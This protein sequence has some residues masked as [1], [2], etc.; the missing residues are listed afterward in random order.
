[1]ILEKPL[2]ATTASH[3]SPP[4]QVILPAGYEIARWVAL[5]RRAGKD[6]TAVFVESATGE[7]AYIVETNSL[8]LAI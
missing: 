5:P 4:R 7:I 3:Y 2:R 1:V 6:R 8:A